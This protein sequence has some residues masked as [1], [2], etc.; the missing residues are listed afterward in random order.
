MFN[1]KSVVARV[2]ADAVKKGN[3]QLSEV[4]NLSNL[5]DIVTILVGEVE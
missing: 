3:K 2:W 5:I 4:P 1:E